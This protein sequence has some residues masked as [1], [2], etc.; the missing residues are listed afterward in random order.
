M[1][2]RKDH[3]VRV[4]RAKARVDICF[5]KAAVAVFVDGCFWHMCPEHRVVPKSNSGY[6]LPKLRANVDRDQRLTSAF[7]AAGWTVLRVWEHVP[8]S[9]AADLVE[10]VVRGRQLPER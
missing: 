7:E 1:R 9:E 5:P 10:A 8:V 4:E 3:F 6:W 2:F